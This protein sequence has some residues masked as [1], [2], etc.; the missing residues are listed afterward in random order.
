M[1]KLEK[2]ISSLE[3]A[4]MVGRRHDQVMRGIDTIINHLVADHKNVVSDYFIFDSYKDSTG[5]TLNSFLLTKKGCELFST[6]M[7]GEKGTQFAIAYIER[8]NE[9]ENH[10][11]EQP[12]LPKNN[13]KLLLETALKHEERMDTIESDVT[14]L[15]D[16]MRISSREESI[17]Q[18]KAKANV[19]EALGGKNSK[20]YE[21][22]NR[23]AFS[24]FW[25]EFKR[26]FT[27]PRYG[28]IPKK[29]FDEAI[30]WINEWQPDTTT[31]IEIKAANDQISMEDDAS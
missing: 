30:D 12:E 24:R 6:R 3:V 23:K 22:M 1:D 2:T 14:F 17:I 7:T 31:R 26:Y 19:V 25:S 21:I 10:I 27:V 5:R 16:T 28:D 18:Q 13:T 29:K 9:M 11:K 4:E 15:K 8:F 20:A